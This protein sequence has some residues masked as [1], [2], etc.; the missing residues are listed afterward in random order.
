MVI[1]TLL[2]RNGSIAENAQVYSS[3][4]CQNTGDRRI[5]KHS[6]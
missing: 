2:Q 4:Q 1:Q 6:L 5:S 3:K